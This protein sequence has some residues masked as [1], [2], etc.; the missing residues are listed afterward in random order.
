MMDRGVSTVQYSRGGKGISR[1]ATDAKK[2][3]VY[4]HVLFAPARQL[5]AASSGEEGEGTPAPYSLAS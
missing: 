3:G 1:E 5:T 2:S 4:Y